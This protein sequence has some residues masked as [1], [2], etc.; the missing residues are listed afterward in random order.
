MKIDE[1]HLISSKVY[2][3]QDFDNLGNYHISNSITSRVFKLEEVSY[4]MFCFLQSSK[5]YKEIYATFNS[6]DKESIKNLINFL[7]NQEII[8]YDDEFKDETFQISNLESTF[9]SFP[10]AYLYDTEKDIIFVS[11]PFGNGN[12]ISNKSQFAPSRLKQYT[13]RYKIDLN[14]TDNINSLAR[15]LSFNIDSK[16]F[17]DTVNKRKIKDLGTLFYYNNESNKS[18]HQKINRLAF[19][20][21]KNKRHPIFIG[22]DHSISY[23]ILQSADKIYKNIIVIHLD[24]HTDTYENILDDLF[25]KSTTNHHGNFALF[26]MELKNITSFYQFGIR[27]FANLGFK[28]VSEKQ[29]IYTTKET[30]ELIEDKI[31]IDLPQNA[32]YYITFDIDVLSPQFTSA[33]STPVPNGL[34]I[35]EIDIL[36]NKILNNKNIIGVDFVEFNGENETNDVS[37]QTSIEIILLLLKNLINS[38]K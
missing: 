34:T 15:L 31:K 9:F 35:S 23:P 10:K 12:T 33:T 25:I 29:N 4:Q 18:Y 3:L 28:E 22:G 26:A 2:S 20:L 37:T 24:A 6:I 1:Q 7:L 17:V 11:L 5:T 27:G 13:K 38:I 21:F 14:L 32:N 8:Y 16:K 19:Q 30:K 36:L